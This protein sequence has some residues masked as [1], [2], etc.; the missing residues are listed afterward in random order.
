MR[1]FLILFF[2]FFSL[3]PAYAGYASIVYDYSNNKIVHDE[4]STTQNIPAS[5]TK[6]MT[7]YLLF[8]RLHSENLSLNDNFYPSLKSVNAPATKI[9]VR[10]KNPIKV[11][12][13]IQALIVQSANDV[14]VMIAENLAGTEENFALLMTDKAK[15]LGMNNT[16]FYNASGLPHAP[17]NVSTA[18]DILILSLAL[19]NDFP[20]YYHY[21]STRM[22]TYGKRTFKNHNHMLETYEGITGIKTGYIRAS[23]FNIAASKEINGHIYFGV[24][25]GMKDRFARDRKM[26]IG[27]AHV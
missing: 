24:V 4:N 20:E 23:G 16:M 7:L 10:Y 2:M 11:E 27:R 25:M 12:D 18:R 22:F 3:S 21:F 5:L 17:Q 1:P 8:E 15:H 14:A 6:M 19:Y 26:E 9:G 13:V